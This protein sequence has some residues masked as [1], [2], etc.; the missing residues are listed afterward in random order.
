MNEIANGLIQSYLEDI[1]LAGSS[2][3]QFVNDMELA[4]SCIQNWSTLYLS[5]VPKP[6][7]FI[8]TERG[9]PQMS[10][11]LSDMIEVEDRVYSPAYGL[12]GDID[13]T[14]QVAVVTKGSSQNHVVPIEI[15][16]SRKNVPISHSAQTMIYTLMAADRYGLYENGVAFGILVYIL[17]QKQFKLHLTKCTWPISSSNAINWL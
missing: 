16:T 14:A 9:M 15:K 11:A 7:A 2:R 3:A 6:Q 17:Q 4:K 13:I 8:E 5:K 1:L 12:K 10:I